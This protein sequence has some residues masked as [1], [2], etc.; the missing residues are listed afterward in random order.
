M[1]KLKHDGKMK[2]RSK[3]RAD[4]VFKHSMKGDD[5][6]S[7]KLLFDFI[8]A[9]TGTRPKSLRY[10]NTEQVPNVIDGKVTISDIQAYD[11]KTKTEYT[12]EMQN[13][14]YTDE[15][16]QRFM[17]VASQ[18]IASYYQAGSSYLDEHYYVQ[19]IVVEDYSGK[20]KL[21]RR[22]IFKGDDN[23]PEEIIPSFERY[24]VFLKE[25]R[26]IAKKKGVEAMDD[27]EKL[28]YL[29]LNDENSVTIV[30]RG[31]LVDA[32][33]RR[34]EILNEN[35]LFKPF[36]LN[37]EDEERSRRSSE[38][39]DHEEWEGIGLEKGIKKGEIKGERRGIIKGEERGKRKTQ[40][41]MLSNLIKQK[42]GSNERKWLKTLTNDQL[43][44][45]ALSIL[46]MST[47]KELKAKIVH[48]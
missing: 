35:T 20:E 43:E 21:I 39:M 42:Y 9:V 31:K 2:V 3:F 18:K 29:Y 16:K 48:N 41:N 27:F 1:K 26:L 10:I 22:F 11:D 4:K 15:Q 6:I 47:L 36:V 24:I 13:S 23:D 37:A 45:L 8:E 38:R 46:T 19:I 17:I 33:M 14:R 7:R 12:I 30:D 34:F 28:C 44:I 32:V 5:E 25:I 40:I